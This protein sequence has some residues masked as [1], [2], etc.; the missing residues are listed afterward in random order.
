M[1]LQMDRARTRRFSSSVYSMQ[2]QV[3]C[4]AMVWTGIVR[5]E[6]VDRFTVTDG[7]VW[8]SAVS[9]TIPDEFPETAE[10]DKIK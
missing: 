1:Y 7:V 4:G 10:S 5:R 8:N 6:F 9:I 2:Y 3:G